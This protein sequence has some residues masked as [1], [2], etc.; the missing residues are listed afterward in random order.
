MARLHPHLGLLPPDVVLNMSEMSAASKRKEEEAARLLPVCWFHHNPN[1]YHLGLT[2]QVMHCIISYP[3][4]PIFKWWARNSCWLLSTKTQ[5]LSSSSPTFP[6]PINII[7]PCHSP[8]T[9]MSS[10]LGE[11]HS[12]PPCPASPSRPRLQLL[13]VTL[14]TLNWRW[15]YCT[16]LFRKGEKAR[17]WWNCLIGESS[18][19]AALLSHIL[20]TPL[21]LSSPSLLPTSRLP[22]VTALLPTPSKT[23][24]CHLPKLPNLPRLLSHYQKKFPPLLFW[25]PSP[26]FRKPALCLSWFS[27][28]MTIQGGKQIMQEKFPWK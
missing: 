2:K 15:R 25:Q 6:F 28:N 21:H 11:C 23:L 7:S 4:K 12:P 24:L 27:R 17:R 26:F 14:A 9:S 20:A 13:Q 3:W 8:S 16:P 10:S 22:G 18:G 5:V 1:C 19:D